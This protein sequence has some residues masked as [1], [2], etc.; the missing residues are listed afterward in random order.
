[1]E[2]KACLTSLDSSWQTI[3]EFSVKTDLAYIKQCFLSIEG[4]ADKSTADFYN[5]LYISDD[6]FG[7]YSKLSADEREVCCRLFGCLNL[8]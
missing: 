7:G 4:G 2:L 5:P 6:P 1:M 8:L 3:P